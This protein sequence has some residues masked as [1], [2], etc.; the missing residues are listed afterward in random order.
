MFFASRFLAAEEEG[1]MFASWVVS[2]CSVGEWCGRALRVLRLQRFKSASPS[3]RELT[4]VVSMAAFV[5][6]YQ[7]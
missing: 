3:G 5:D 1:K 2:R 6:Y 7:S 4:A